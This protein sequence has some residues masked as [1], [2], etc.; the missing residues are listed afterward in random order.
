MDAHAGTPFSSYTAQVK[1]CSLQREKD[2]RPMAGLGWPKMG[3]KAACRK[4]VFCINLGFCY[5]AG[6]GL[7]RSIHHDKHK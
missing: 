3:A 7:Q 6:N 4:K 2:G 5:N 1:G